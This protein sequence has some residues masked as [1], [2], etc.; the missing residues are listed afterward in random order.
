MR[1][2]SALI[3][4]IGLAS[5]FLA[6]PARMGLAPGARAGVARSTPPIA[7]GIGFTLTMLANGQPALSFPQ[8]PGQTAAPLGVF[9]LDYPIGTPISFTEDTSQLPTAIDIGQ[10][11]WVWDFGDSSQSDGYTVSH[12]FAKPGIYV[13]RVSLHDYQDPSAQVS[14]FDSAQITLTSQPYDR[15]PTAAIQSSA[16]YVQV[17]HSVTYAVASAHSY[18]GGGLT[19]TWNFGD[20]TTATGARVTHVYRQLGNGSVALIVQDRRGARSFFTTPVTIVAQ[21]PVARLTASS[22]QITAGSSVTLD[23]SGSVAPA[24]SPNDRIVSYHWDFGD[25]ATQTTIDPR[26]QH[27][28]AQAGTY[29]VTVQAVDRQGIPGA[30]TITIEVDNAL[31]WRIALWLSAALILGSAAYIL[32]QI[33]IHIAKRGKPEAS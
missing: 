11:T 16:Q 12:V 20:N 22:G 5:M 18:V 8:T 9:A 24:A 23:A 4:Q 2:I 7:C 27:T 6:T 15:L 13:V 10:Y 21:L 1:A 3:L 14:N 28:F 31:I 33:A 17:G 26:V 19:Y 30:A 29:T 32:Y 25:G